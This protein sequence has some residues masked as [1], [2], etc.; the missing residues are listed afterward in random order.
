M[1]EKKGDCVESPTSACAVEEKAGDGNEKVSPCLDEVSSS[2]SSSSKDNI[3]KFA[4]PASWEAVGLESPLEEGPAEEEAESLEEQEEDHPEETED[5]VDDIQ[6]DLYFHQMEMIAAEQEEVEEAASSSRGPEVPVSDDGS[7]PAPSTVIVVTAAA[8]PYTL[9]N[10]E[11]TEE[12]WEIWRD[13]LVHSGPNKGQK[14]K[15]EMFRRFKYFREQGEWIGS[16]PDDR[17][18]SARLAARPKSAGGKPS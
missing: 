4:Y 18:K 3:P 16:T 14:R 13:V 9:P 5:E 2:S 6:L 8:D 15:L 11:W 17:A 12:D 1:A 7:V 10:Q